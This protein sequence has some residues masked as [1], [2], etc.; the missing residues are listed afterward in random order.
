VDHIALFNCL[1]K[2]GTGPCQTFKTN[3]NQA[4]YSCP[5]PFE[6]PRK[7]RV[8]VKNADPSELDVMGLEDPI[9]FGDF[10]DIKHVSRRIIQ[11]HIHTQSMNRRQDAE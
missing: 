4:C 10:Q 7:R 1:S 9:Q 3:H 8:L 2:P 5:S 6:V 11:M